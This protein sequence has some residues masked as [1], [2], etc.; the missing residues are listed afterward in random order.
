MWTLEAA[1]IGWF[2]RAGAFDSDPLR[3]E[4]TARW[5][6]LTAGRLIAAAA[7]VAYGY[8]IYQDR[9]LYRAAADAVMVGMAVG[10]ADGFFTVSL[11]TTP[12]E[13]RIAAYRGLTAFL[14][15]FLIYLAMGTASVVTAWVLFHSP[16]AQFVVAVAFFAFGLVDSIN[17]WLDVPADVTRALS[18]RS[19]RRDERFAAVARGITVAAMVSGW[20][21][22]L[23]WIASAPRDGIGPAMVVGVGYG[24][25][26]RLMGLTT[27]VWGRYLITKTWAAVSGDVP[28]R[29]MLFLDDAHRRGVLRRA[30]AIYQFR[31]ARLQQHLVR[32]G[33]G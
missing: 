33:N 9:P 11:R 5:V 16:Y 14:R 26:D 12:T 10:L 6:A 23:Y 2:G 30:G 24:L 32:S 7:G 13:M 25:A 8:T 22:A 19:T 3:R 18:P 21:L 20:T 28:V 27:S 15:R 31:H 17:V 1:L 4:Q 29:L